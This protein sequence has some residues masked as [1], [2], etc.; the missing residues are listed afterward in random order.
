M[1]CPSCPILHPSLHLSHPPCPHPRPQPQGELMNR[2]EN[3]VQ[4][5]QDYVDTAKQDTKKAIRYQSKA[6]RKKLMCA[7]IGVGVMLLLILI[8]VLYF[9]INRDNTPSTPPAATHP[10]PDGG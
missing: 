4:E 2:I 10:P 3:H 8:L 9:I 5:A 7:A 1:T 6:R